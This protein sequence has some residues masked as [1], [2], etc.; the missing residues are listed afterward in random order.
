MLLRSLSAVSQGLASKSRLAAL[1]FKALPLA[2]YFFA[3]LVRR[4][5]DSVMQNEAGSIRRQ[6]MAFQSLPNDH[7]VPRCLIDSPQLNDGLDFQGEILNGGRPAQRCLHITG[8]GTRGVVI[9]SGVTID[10]SK[11][12]VLVPI[13]GE[14]TVTE[15]VTCVLGGRVPMARPFNAKSQLA[16][17]LL[18]NHEQLE[19]TCPFWCFNADGSTGQWR[20]TWD[21]APSSFHWRTIDMP[22]G[23][24]GTGFNRWINDDTF[25]NQALIKDE[26][27]RVL[28]DGT[29][30]KQR[31]K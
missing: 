28:L 1:P 11:P 12:S 22:T 4:G 6:S 9:A 5:V 7:A 25:D 19:K 14:K 29:Q 31:K 18:A 24:I 23:W 16:T 15:K 30:D 13:R 17:I 27:G 26:N 20:V 21:A 2:A 10:R 3:M 8:Q